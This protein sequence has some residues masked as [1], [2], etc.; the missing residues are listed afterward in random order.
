M[1]TINL[2]NNLHHKSVTEHI[3]PYFKD[4]SVPVISYSY[5]STIAPKVFNYKQV[6]RDYQINDLKAKPPDCSC[7]KSPFKYSPSGHVITGDL[8]IVE[9][10]QLR[11]VLAKG[12]KYR[13]PRAIN[14]NHNFK[15]I[16]DS[17]ED[18]A[19]KWA[20]KEHEKESDVLSG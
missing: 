9:N 5:T 4:K 16:M 19:R 13:E 6:L 7:D 12:P 2:G 1:D 17:V 20:K 10:D 11:D 3:P 15:T 8:N 14:W 18:Y